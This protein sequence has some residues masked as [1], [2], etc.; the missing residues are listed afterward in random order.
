MKIILK[1]KKSMP[2]KPIDLA[3]LEAHML[4]MPNQVEIPTEHI[5]SGGVYIR[6]V[7]I[8]A[9]TIIMG[10]RHRYS[11][12]NI[13]LKGVLRVYVDPGEP[14]ITITGPRIFTSPPNAKKFAYCQ[15]E[16][17]FIN[18]IPTTETDPDEIERQFIIPEQ[19]YLELQEA[20]KCHSLPLQ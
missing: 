18:V 14:P 12:C 10:M 5:F 2:V 3:A 19:E 15:E 1:R 9:G 16:A 13:L 8:P 11:T 7:T 17:V 6:Q 20:E 4:T